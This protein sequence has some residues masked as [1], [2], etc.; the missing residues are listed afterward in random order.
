MRT[1]R[2]SEALKWGLITA[3][4]MGLWAPVALRALDNVT[5]VTVAASQ[6]MPVAQ[7]ALAPAFSAGVG[8]ILRM[9]EAKVDLEVIKAYINNSRT[10]YNPSADEIIALK[11]R[12]VS[13][14]VLT[15]MLQ[16]GAQVRAQAAQAAQGAATPAVPQ[17]VLAAGNPYAPTYTYPYPVTSYAYPTYSYDYP[18]Y[19]YGGYNYGSYWPWYWPSLYFGWYPYGGYCGYPYHYCGYRYPYCYGGRGYGYYHGG[20]I[21]YGGRS[22]SGGHGYYGEHGYVGSAGHGVP[23][24]GRSGGFRSFGGSGRPATF[25]SAGGGFR[26]GGGISGH[27][28]SFGGHGGGFG[29]HSMRRGR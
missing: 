15:A 9:V 6:D 1:A 28:G 3:G 13:S 22:Y 27:A 29:G 26:G 4:M 19:Y 2:R 8:D 12:G 18:V 24:A 16:H 5:P 11:D 14:E 20:H 21:Y 25:V 17:T 7:S 23:Y 10:A